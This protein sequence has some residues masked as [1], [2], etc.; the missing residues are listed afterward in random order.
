[1]QQEIASS[2]E[3][4]FVRCARRACT[5]ISPRSAIAPM[6]SFFAS[7]MK[8]SSIAGCP[9]ATDEDPMRRSAARVAIEYTAP[10]LG[11]KLRH[12]ASGRL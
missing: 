5:Q 1:M 6:G 3:L 9:I 10:P 2:A 11:L 4:I 8:A 12:N 7:E